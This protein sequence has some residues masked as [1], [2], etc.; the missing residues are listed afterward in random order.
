MC[1][2]SWCIGVSFLSSEKVLVSL[3]YTADTVLRYITILSHLKFLKTV[4]NVELL[5]SHARNGERRILL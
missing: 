5:Y 4:I 1:T 2:Q 3:I